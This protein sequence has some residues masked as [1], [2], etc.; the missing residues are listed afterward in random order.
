MHP[1][2]S[3]TKQKVIVVS[4]ISVAAVIILGG[5]AYAM[6]QF[7]ST[8][9]KEQAAAQES[10]GHIKSDK[11]V[12]KQTLNQGMNDLADS[13]EESKAVHTETEAV[14]KD[15]STQVKVSQ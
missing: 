9:N 15:M 4:L 10:T 12:T 13:I 11:G 1:T 5:A 6:M 3:K 14:I 2:Q 8:K 7:V